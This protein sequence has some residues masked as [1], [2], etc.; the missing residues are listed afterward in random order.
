MFEVTR[1][2]VARMYHTIKKLLIQWVGIRFTTDEAE[3]I[4]ADALAEMLYRANNS[5]RTVEGPYWE[6]LTIIGGRMYNT[7]AN[8]GYTLEPEEMLPYP[9][10]SFKDLWTFIRCYC[11]WTHAKSLVPGEP[12]MYSLVYAFL[13][14]HRYYDDPI[15]VSRF[16][17]DALQSCFKAM[18]ALAETFEAHKY[19]KHL[20]CA[21]ANGF[22]SQ[23]ARKS[24]RWYVSLPKETKEVNSGQQGEDNDIPRTV[25]R[26]GDHQVL[27]CGPSET[28][29][30][31]HRLRNDLQRDGD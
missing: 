25:E 19:A 12:L 13:R 9:V 4:V 2:D 16:T 20:G 18:T 8:R 30:A 6:L 26:V 11:W 3:R 17:E 24:R 7:A 5:V 14:T 28:R 21:E 27:G 23:E 10:P 15:F 22:L 29:P 1:E 31:Q